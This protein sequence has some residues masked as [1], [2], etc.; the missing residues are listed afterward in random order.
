[1]SSRWKIVGAAVAAGLVL[2][3]G[4]GVAVAASGER[5]GKALAGERGPMT[6][7]ASYLGLTVAQLREALHDDKSLAEIARE[8]GKSVEGLKQAI[9]AD[10]EQKLSQAVTDGRI[11]AA[12]KQEMLERLNEHIDELVN[13][14]GPPMRGECRG[15]TEGAAVPA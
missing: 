2:V 12:Q 6:A 15:P 8:Q 3:I 11:T 10:A 7:V 13:R 9:R 1:M 5:G 4:T 14:T